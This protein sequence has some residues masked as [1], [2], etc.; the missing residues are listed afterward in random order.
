MH[1]FGA[2]RYS[3][4]PRTG[5]GPRPGGWGPLIYSTGVNLHGNSDSTVQRNSNI[6][7]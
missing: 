1:S 6:I 3:I 5:D 4:N 7:I 2:P